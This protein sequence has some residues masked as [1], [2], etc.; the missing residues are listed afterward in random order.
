MLIRGRCAGCSDGPV[1]PYAP[2]S[3]QMFDGGG[4]GLTN[5]AIVF[6]Y[7]SDCERMKLSRKGDFT[8]FLVFVGSIILV[9]PLPYPSLRS[10]TK[11]HHSSSTPSSFTG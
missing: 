10:P 2:P 9:R 8:V 6:K 5:L 7:A 11:T 3:T 1:F 4:G